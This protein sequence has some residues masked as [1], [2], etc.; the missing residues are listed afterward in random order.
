MGEAFRSYSDLMGRFPDNTAGLIVP[1]CCRD[2]LLTRRSFGCLYSSA[3]GVTGE[4]RPDADNP[5][6][7]SLRGLAGV[8]MFPGALP[9]VDYY[10]EQSW[11]RVP[12]DGWYLI[13]A[14]M[15]LTD[16][17]QVGIFLNGAA[18]A[19]IVWKSTSPGYIAGDYGATPIAK[20]YE[21]FM[22]AR[23][24]TAKTKLEI[25]TRYY[26]GSVPEPIDPLATQAWLMAVR[27]G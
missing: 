26:D 2:L 11:F 10:Q 25:G 9:W 21:T 16:N 17:V 7:V 8:I 1:E 23:E 27:I 14:C 19:S 15:R 18:D 24:L 12:S 20:R 13:I 6:W 22:A 5:T 3:G 4:A